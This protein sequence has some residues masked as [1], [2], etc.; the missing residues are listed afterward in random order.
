MKLT[1]GNH[2]INVEREGNPS[3]QTVVMAHS[4]GCNLHMWDPQMQALNQDFDVI[5]LDMRG[6]GKSDAPAGPY[7]LEDLADDAAHIANVEKAEEFSSA[8]LAFLQTA[9]LRAAQVEN[10]E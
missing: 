9:T 10:Q 4:L 1:I 7:S 3:G 6:H 8:L 2:R 5:R